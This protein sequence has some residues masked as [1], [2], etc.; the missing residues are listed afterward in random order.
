M[1]LYGYDASVYNS[2]Q[3]STNWDDHF[4]N[5]VKNKDTELI[6]LVNSAYTIGA[7]IAGWFLGGPLADYLGRRWGMGTWLSAIFYF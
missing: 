3:G 4:G 2:V 1:V 5:P 6:G 7:I